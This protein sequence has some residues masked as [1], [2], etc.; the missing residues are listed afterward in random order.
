MFGG[1]YIQ[2]GAGRYI[3]YHGALKQIGSEALCYGTR[4]FLLVSDDLIY[5]KTMPKIAE[6]LNEAGV[7]YKAFIFTGPSTTKSFEYIAQ[8]VIQYQADII[9]G[10]GGGRI[11]DIAKGA[12]DI[13]NVKIITV[14]TSAATCAAFAVLYVVYKEDGSIEKSGFLKHEI[15][16]V[17]VDTDF[18]VNDCPM[19]YLASGIADAMAKKPEFMFTMLNLGSEGKIA[20]SDIATLIADYTYKNYLAKGVQTIE[21]FMGKKDEGLLD[22][23]VCMNIMLTGMVSDLSTGGKQLAIA[24]N[25]YDAICCLHHEIR[26][27]YL[28]GEIV[29]LALPLQI[30]INGGALSEINE[31]KDFL[32]QIG[33][34]TSLLEIGFP[35]DK[36]KLDELITYI[37]QKTIADNITLLNKLYENMKYIM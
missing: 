6:S 24:H 36:E 5:E 31:C 20:T 3:Q 11:L 37:H 25:F 18:V 29:G 27:N 14:P 2:V 17:I 7:D 16:A 10:V 32:K 30:A 8:Q 23:I 9:I 33:C 22:D 12:G 34:P 13:A 4:V 28:H 26:Q 15:S 19:R 21:E 35:K 1:S